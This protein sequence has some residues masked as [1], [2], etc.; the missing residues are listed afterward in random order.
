MY[1]NI[2]MHVYIYI[3]E[4]MYTYV[5]IYIYVFISLYEGSYNTNSRLTT[6]RLAHFPFAPS[7]LMQV[8][9]FHFVIS[10]LSFFVISSFSFFQK[11]AGVFKH[12]YSSTTDLPI[13]NI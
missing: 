12:H 10:C 5:Y 7:A 6:S 11:N 8:L 2:C 1:I 4:Y 9:R 13:L 3:Y